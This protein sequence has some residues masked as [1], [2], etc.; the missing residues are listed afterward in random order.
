MNFRSGARWTHYFRRY[1]T[2]LSWVE[3]HG[4]HRLHWLDCNLRPTV[5]FT[6]SSARASPGLESAFSRKF[7]PRVALRYAGKFL[8]FNLQRMMV[9]A[10]F[11]SAGLVSFAR[12]VNETRKMAALRLVVPALD[13][14]WRLVLATIV[15]INDYASSPVRRQG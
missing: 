4:H 14:R 3:G 9:V 2:L 6:L 1:L 5:D 11:A 8:N 13:I 15:P 12:G 10:H 7:R